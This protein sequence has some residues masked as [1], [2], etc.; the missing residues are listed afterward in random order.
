M[1]KFEFKIANFLC[2][3]IEFTLDSRELFVTNDL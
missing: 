2:F 1:P 3:L